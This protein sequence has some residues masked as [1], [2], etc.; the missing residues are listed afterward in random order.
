MTK[1]HSFHVYCSWIVTASESIFS[2][3]AGNRSRVNTFLNPASRREFNHQKELRLN[4]PLV[5]S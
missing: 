1:L 2:E 5:L 3:I 4:S